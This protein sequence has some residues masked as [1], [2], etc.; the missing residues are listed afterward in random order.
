MMFRKSGTASKKRTR[1]L[2]VLLAIVAAGTYWL[3]ATD[4][5]G[6]EG[7]HPVT[8]PDGKPIFQTI[9]NESQVTI[10]KEETALLPQDEPVDWSAYPQGLGVLGQHHL[11]HP[12]DVS[13]WPVDIGAR[14][15]IFC[16]S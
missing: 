2:V 1:I 10:A 13:D 8:S 16:K 12:V 7:N 3:T 5:V 6:G 14:R 11:M 9:S 4:S 15:Q